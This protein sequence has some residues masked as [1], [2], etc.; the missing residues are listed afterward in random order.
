MAAM[1]QGDPEPVDA[2]CVRAHYART[3]WHWADALEAHLDEAQR[4]LG[5]NAEKIIRA[6]RLYL[7]GSAMG[8]E[9]GWTSLFQILASRP[10]D[11]AEQR[12]HATGRLSFAQRDY[13]FNRGDVYTQSSTAEPTDSARAMS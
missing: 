5:V 12:D 3:L 11:M 7:A 4:T 2:E 10:A 8:F 13:P 6:Y 1:T 9:R